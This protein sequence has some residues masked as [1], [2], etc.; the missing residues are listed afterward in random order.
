MDIISRQYII[1][2]IKKKY[3]AND[4]YLW[5]KYP[6]YAVFRHKDNKKWFAIIMNIP[7]SK[8]NIGANGFIDVLNVKC[9][10]FVVDLVKDYKKIFPAYHMNKSK[11][12]SIV[13]N[14][15]ITEKELND[16]IEIS[17]NLTK[18]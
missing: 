2:F 7:K 9:D 4:E 18:K 5:I 14:N 17:Y 12:I 6:T 10:P 16:F 1:E 8:L 13:L 3:N 15:D 11:W